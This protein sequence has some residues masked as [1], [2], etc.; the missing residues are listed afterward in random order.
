MN[1]VYQWTRLHQAIF[2]GVYIHKLDTNNL[3]TWILTWEIIVDLL[4]VLHLGHG[5][6]IFL[7]TCELVLGKAVIM[8]HHRMKSAI[9]RLI[10]LKIDLD[11][12][13]AKFKGR[14]RDG[15]ASSC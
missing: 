9:D 1:L 14:R 10:V 8:S 12:L 7:S 4:V 5:Q 15:H 2:S 13:I 6:C 3:A 11:R